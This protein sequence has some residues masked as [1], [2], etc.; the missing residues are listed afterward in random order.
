MNVVF[1]TLEGLRYDRVSSFNKELNYMTY[2][3]NSLVKQGIC[4]H[5]FRLPNPICKENIKTLQKEIVSKVDIDIYYSDEVV[6]EAIEHFE[7]QSPDELFLFWKHFEMN[8]PER[9]ELSLILIQEQL[10]KM[11]EWLDG[12]KYLENTALILMGTSGFY[13]NEKHPMKIFKDVHTSLYD[14]HLH[15]PLVV[16]YPDCRPS[17]VLNSV[18]MDMIPDVIVDLL[19]GKE[20]TGGM[21]QLCKGKDKIRK[22]I[23]SKYK[24]AYGLRGPMYQ[25]YCQLGKDKKVLH[26]ELYDLNNDV[27]MRKDLIKKQDELSSQVLDLINVYRG[28]ILDMA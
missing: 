11:I 20:T 23:Y 25:Y 4:F 6:D 21:T 2:V 15:V 24:S 18:S 5:N 14:E 7:E 26:Q 8:Q 22:D 13:A 16:F 12:K 10:R 27:E 1:F 9:P 3:V 17:D 28:R 19:Y